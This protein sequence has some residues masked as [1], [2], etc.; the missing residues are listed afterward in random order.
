MAQLATLG[1][2]DLRIMM[3]P[4]QDTILRAVSFGSFGPAAIYGRKS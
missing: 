3:S 1:F 4:V 2:A